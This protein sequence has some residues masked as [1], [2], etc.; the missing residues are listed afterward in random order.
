MSLIMRKMAVVCCCVFASSAYADGVPRDVQ[1]GPA[2][3]TTGQPLLNARAT[4]IKHGWK[5]IRRHTDD[6][7]EYSGAELELT[8][9]KIFE[10][11]TCSSDSSRCVLFYAKK[12]DCLRMDTIGERL[13]WMTVTRWANECPDAPPRRSGA[14][15]S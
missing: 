12:G 14:G 11:D 10:V 4:L 1:R 9:R 13:N 6:G 7:Y 3:I 2:G 8:A 5:P 15:G